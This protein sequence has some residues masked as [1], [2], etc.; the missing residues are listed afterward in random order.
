MPFL[1]VT[2]RVWRHP[3]RTPLAWGYAAPVLIVNAILLAC[4]V[5]IAIGVVF[6]LYFIFTGI[7]RVDPAAAHTPISF[8]VL[9]L[10][11]A[12]GLWPMLLLRVLRTSQSGRGHA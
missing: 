8:R 9:M 1:D 12:A 11:G 6:G 3:T 4:G 5:Y 2:H 7:A 10:P